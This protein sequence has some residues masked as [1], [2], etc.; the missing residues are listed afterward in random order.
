MKRIRMLDRQGILTKIKTP[1]ELRGITLV[2]I[3]YV[4]R[5]LV[6][7][8]YLK[9]EDKKLDI[10]RITYKE[11]VDLEC[12]EYNKMLEKFQ[13]WY[14][15]AKTY[16]FLFREIVEYIDLGDL[17]VH[18]KDRYGAGVIEKREITNVFLNEG[19]VLFIEGETDVNKE[20]V[21]RRRFNNYITISKEDGR[22]IYYVL[23]PI[24]ESTREFIVNKG[25]LF[26]AIYSYS[27]H[28]IKEF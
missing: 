14:V 15:C 27:K 20:G 10:K 28:R 24:R 4:I 8:G 6:E 1:K 3:I 17:M 22:L 13:L 26:N 11:R 19:N 21:L 2:E 16:D 12:I 23:L 18:I 25:T 5:K 9:Y 7:Q